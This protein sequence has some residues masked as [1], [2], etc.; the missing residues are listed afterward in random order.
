MAAFYGHA[1]SIVW[2]E[3]RDV[4]LWKLVELA[5]K[6]TARKTPPLGRGAQGGSCVDTHPRDLADCWVTTE[7]LGPDLCRCLRRF[8]E[9]GG[10]VN[11]KKLE[12]LLLVRAPTNTASR[13]FR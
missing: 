13:G 8:E 7:R 3:T 2:G 9:R 11:W 10:S 4:S 5:R 12:Q 6:T 1:T